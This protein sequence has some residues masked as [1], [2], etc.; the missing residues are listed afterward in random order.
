MN[1]RI[2]DISILVLLLFV[3]TDLS[4]Q[5]SKPK[6]K[7]WYDDK[8]FHF[9]FSLGVNAMDYSITPS[10]DAYVVDSLFSEVTSLNPGINIQIITNLRLNR[11][12]D[13]RFLPGVS[14]GERTINY[15]RKEIPYKQSQTLESSYLEFP[16]TLKYKGER[17]NNVRPYV[18]AGVNFRYDLS[19]KK[20]FNEDKPVYIRIKRPD[21]Y[22]EAGAG[23]DFYLHYFKLGVELKM[24][25][26]IGNIIVNDAPAGFE[27]YRSAI[28]KL[29]SRIW[30]LSFHFE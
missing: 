28:D 6:N 22:Y 30:V 27:E 13:L 17:L 11:Y 29:K 3:S 5:K 2:F 7:S 9:G 8:L 26:G 19:G 14:F 18:V 1:R 15:Y 20:E 12:M 25:Q 4:A 10:Q 24:S 16:L 23:L 21:L